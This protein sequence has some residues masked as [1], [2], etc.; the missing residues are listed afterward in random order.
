MGYELP[1][2]GLYST[3]IELSSGNIA[4]GS[5]VCGVPP[6]KISFYQLIKTIQQISSDGYAN[7][8]FLLEHVQNHY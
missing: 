1:L 5:A 8:L 6:G 3:T 7:C 4:L 2:A